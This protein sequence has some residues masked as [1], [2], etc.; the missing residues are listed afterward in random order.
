MSWT[1]AFSSSLYFRKG[2]LGMMIN[3]LILYFR[4]IKCKK[5]ANFEGLFMSWTYHIWFI[6]G[7]RFDIN[8]GDGFD[9]RVKLF[10]WGYIFSSIVSEGTLKISYPFVILA[11]SVVPAIGCGWQSFLFSC[12]IWHIFFYYLVRS[13]F[14]RCFE[15]DTNGCYFQTMFLKKYLFDL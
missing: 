2:G 9:I 6:I 1:E 8:I 13:C 12:E 7:E 10:L 4:G 14:E 3:P 5:S 11:T 15:G